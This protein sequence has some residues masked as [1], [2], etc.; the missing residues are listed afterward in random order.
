MKG[1]MSL[2]VGMRHRIEVHL[3]GILNLR[4][5]LTVRIEQVLVGI[6]RLQ[7]LPLLLP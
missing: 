3:A 1:M 5:F 6:H 4:K 7:L 2:A